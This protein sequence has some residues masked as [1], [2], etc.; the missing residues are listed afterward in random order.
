MRR[1][2]L[3]LLAGAAALTPRLA[4]AQQRERPRIGY[5]ISWTGSPRAPV[6]VAETRALVEGLRELGWYDGRNVTIDHRFSGTGRERI[7][8]NAQELVAS[9]PDVIV[10][11][12]GLQLAALL[13]ETRTIPIVFT[14]VGDP[15]ASGFVESLARP[16]GN[17]TGI[18][19]NEAPIAGKW[20]ELL[21]EAAPATSR[22]VVL[23][24]AES[25][26][27]QLLAEAAAAAAAPLGM[28]AF[29]ASVREAADYDREIEAFA[30][31]PG[32]GLVV[33]SNP[34]MAN[35]LERIQALAERYRLPAVYSYPIFARAG[36]F[37]AYGPDPPPLFRQAAAYVDRIL[38]GASPSD[39]PVQQPTRFVLAVN[40][41]TAQALGLTVPQSLLARADEVIE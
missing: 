3:G 22:A 5:F 15:V 37:I 29:L 11:V 16:G 31:E 41:K 35:S 20:L 14:M 28:T 27:Q 18:G 7:Q 2:N 23:M 24:Q 19:F 38:R 17:A 9:R 26:P 13:A 10:S 12:G 40:I 1:R 25:R 32:G 6:G 33:L 8:A 21:K 36:G 34:V 30:R 39:L 4:T